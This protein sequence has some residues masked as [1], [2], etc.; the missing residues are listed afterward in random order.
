[1]AQVTRKIGLSLGADIC[2]PICF[3]EILNRLQLEIPWEGD[4]VRL[5]VEGRLL[6]QRRF[7]SSDEFHAVLERA[8][9]ERLS[10]TLMRASAIG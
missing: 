2:W 10:F 8:P 3:E 7:E 4:R 5:Q 6:P 1:M 9:V